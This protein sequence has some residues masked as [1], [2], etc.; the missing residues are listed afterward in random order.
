MHPPRIAQPA[1]AKAAGRG[2][3]S[4]KS[5]R[6]E[7]AYRNK[8]A[9]PDTHTPWNRVGSR[10]TPA[11]WRRART[12]PT[13]STLAI[14]ATTSGNGE[15]SKA[16]GKAGSKGGFSVAP[17][18]GE[19]DS[20]ALKRGTTAVAM[21]RDKSGT[22]I[23]RPIMD[24]TGRQP[25]SASSSRIAPARTGEGGGAGTAERMAEAAKLRNMRS[26][27]Q[28]GER[29]TRGKDGKLA[30]V[31]DDASA[32]VKPYD[33]SNWNASPAAP[34]FASSSWGVWSVDDSAFKGQSQGFV[35]RD[36][37]AQRRIHV[38]QGHDRQGGQER[39]AVQQ[40][41]TGRRLTSPSGAFLDEGPRRKPG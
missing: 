27:V 19:R 41:K 33:G 12:S 22:M 34:R 11:S 17:A 3:R 20:V 31:R 10:F 32:D 16:K 30:Y 8:I 21:V 7:S 15:Y 29:L 40:S 25:K 14:S 26:R 24:D 4:E 36:G 23:A 6:W 38:P 39:A 9:K 37:Q 28:P 18:T 1:Q 35:G 2:R 13:R 5:P